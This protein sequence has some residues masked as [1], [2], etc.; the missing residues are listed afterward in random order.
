MRY[1]IRLFLATLMFI[2]VTSAQDVSR[3]QKLQRIVDLDTEVKNSINEYL[4]PDAKDMAEAAGVG[5][6]VFRI[7]P[8]GKIDFQ[9]GVRGGGAYYSFSTKSHDYDSKPQIELQQNNLSVGFAGANYGFIKDL[10]EISLASINTESYAVDFLANYRPPTNI[11]EIRSEQ[12]KSRDFQIDGITY[13]RELAAI[14][15]NTYV[16]RSISFE[17]ADALVAFKI[18]RKDTDGSLII[19][20]KMLK[21]FEKPKIGRTAV[22]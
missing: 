21:E 9:I 10:G 13:K 14:V 3:E 11:S 17:D 2:T 4:A 15:G 18:H 8:R 16:L 7:I 1:I 6:E 12:S 20:W 5:A 19:F 22:K